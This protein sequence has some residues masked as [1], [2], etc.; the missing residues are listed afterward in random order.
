MLEISQPSSKYVYI[1]V[2]APNSIVAKLVRTVKGDKYTHVGVAFEEDIRTMYSFSRKYMHFP[3][4]GEMATESLD[5]GFLSKCKYLSGIV[6][7]IPV[8]EEKYN[9]A[10][11]MVLNMYAHKENYK[12]NIRGLLAHTVPIRAT[13]NNKFT[14]SEFVAHI[15]A[16]N[17]IHK[18]MKPLSRIRPQEMSEMG[19]E[20]VYEGNL[21]GYKKFA[22]T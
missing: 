15:L 19:F 2:C 17:E 8:S 18:F 16:D 21:F 12:Y 5:R 14:C 1:I 10:R 20:T 4:I 9:A 6:M 7:R 22:K 11:D 3:F 13:S